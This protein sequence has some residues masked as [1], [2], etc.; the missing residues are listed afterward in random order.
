LA[1][2]IASAENPLTARVMVNRIWQQMIGRGLVRTA[3]NFGKLGERPTHP[4]LLDH[5]AA[6]FVESG[7]SVK[8]LA[9][10]IAL[11]STFAQTSFVAPE[12]ARTDPENRHVSHANRRRLTYEELRDSLLHL[13]GRLAQDSATPASADG[14]DGCRRTMFS[15]IDRRKIDATAA[16]FDGPDSKSIVPM[17]AESTTAAQ[18]LF[19]MNNELTLETAKKLAGELTKDSSLVDDRARFERLWLLALGRPP[20]PDEVAGLPE[21]VA[22]HGWERLVQA[23]LGTNEF[24]YLD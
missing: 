14:E 6:R 20:A 16:I 17:R 15:P 24:T 8:Q 5:L 4:E 12:V 10:A 21:F 18:A 9:R 22:R 13:G 1:E 3:D 19:L 23:V 7:W 11:S 2:W